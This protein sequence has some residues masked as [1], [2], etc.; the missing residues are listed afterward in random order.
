LVSNEPVEFNSI[1]SEEKLDDE[2]TNFHAGDRIGIGISARYDVTQPPAEIRVLYYSTSHPSHMKI[3]TSSIS[4]DFINS[5]ISGRRANVNTKITA[6]FGIYD[7]VDYD[8]QITTPSGKSITEIDVEENES[9]VGSNITLQITWDTSES[10]SCNRSVRVTVL[11]N[12]NNHWERLET[13]YFIYSEGDISDDAPSNNE[14]FDGDSSGNE[15]SVISLPNLIILLAIGVF[16][17]FLI[18]FF[19]SRKR[20]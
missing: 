15:K 12:N 3:S 8:I 10:D 17:I 16:I 5:K 20:G 2:L 11:D 1:I 4:I 9:C 6:A 7:I 19:L 13:L 14:T 18:Y